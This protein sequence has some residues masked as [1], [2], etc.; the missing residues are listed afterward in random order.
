MK[1][2]M[3]GVG[4]REAEGKI[5]MS[6]CKAFFFQVHMFTKA[7]IL[8][9]PPFGGAS[10]KGVSFL[11]LDVCFHFFLRFHLLPG[12]SRTHSSHPSS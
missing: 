7:A 12:C 9:L 8:S 3:G 1:V 11:S 10:N 2:N 6:F 5:M 4:E